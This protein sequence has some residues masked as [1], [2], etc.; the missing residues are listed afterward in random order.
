MEVTKTDI[1]TVACSELTQEQW[2]RL[3]SRI[4]NEFT[5]SEKTF[6]AERKNGY[7]FLT[8]NKCDWASFIKVY[9]NGIGIDK[10]T[11]LGNHTDG[12]D[13]IQKGTYK[14]VGKFLESQNF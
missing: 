8:T 11:I 1:N 6:T 2:R 7:Y 12:W 5:G 3:A 10:I 4:D 14:G 13:E 9:T